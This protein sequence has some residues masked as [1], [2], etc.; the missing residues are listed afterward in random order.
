MQI[1]RRRPVSPAGGRA[2]GSPPGC[3]S[4]AA[5]DGHHAA[6]PAAAMDPRSNIAPSQLRACD[7]AYGRCSAGVPGDGGRPVIDRP[8]PINLDRRQARKR[9]CGDVTPAIR[10]RPSQPV[11]S[12]L[13]LSACCNR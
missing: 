8:P 4:R 10:I 12:L 2:D 6:A 3:L 7:A 1:Y 9:R 13:C 5:G 11:A